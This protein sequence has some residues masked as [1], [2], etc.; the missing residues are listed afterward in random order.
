MGVITIYRAEVPG[1]IVEFCW[2]SLSCTAPPRLE[3]AFGAVHTWRVPGIEQAR[4]AVTTAED[5]ALPLGNSPPPKW[6]EQ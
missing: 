3:K 1:V 2:Q 6:G 5:R 4:M